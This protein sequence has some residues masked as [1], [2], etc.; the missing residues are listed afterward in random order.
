MATTLLAAERKIVTPARPSRL[1]AWVRSHPMLLV[2]S[3][4]VLFL[5]VAALMPGL[6]ASQATD[7]LNMKEALQGPSFRHLLGTDE[8]G[9]DI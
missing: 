6:L 7:G 3:L 9:R 1:V 4:C 5:L 2:S 8:A